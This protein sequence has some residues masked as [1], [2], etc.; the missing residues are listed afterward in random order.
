MDHGN[1]TIE[2]GDVWFCSDEHVTLAPTSPLTVGDRVYVIP[3]H[4]DPTI[5]YHEAYQ[6]ADGADLGAVVIERW[7]IDLRGWQV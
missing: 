6:L 4:V 3:A 7:P 5:A 2:G 1:P